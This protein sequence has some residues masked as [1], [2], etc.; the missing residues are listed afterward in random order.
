MSMRA[1]ISRAQHH[2]LQRRIAKSRKTKAIK[3]RVPELDRVSRGIR[4][5]QRRGLDEL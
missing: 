4:M 1:L 2:V 3:D 5:G